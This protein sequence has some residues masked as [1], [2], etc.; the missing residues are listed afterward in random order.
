MPAPQQAAGS[1]NNDNALDFLWLVVIIVVGMALVWYFGKTP[2]TRAVFFVRQYELIAIQA[3]LSIWNKVLI[4]TQVPIPSANT[5]TLLQWQH[6][7]KNTPTSSVNFQALSALSTEVGR[8]LAYPIAGILGVLAIFIYRSNL[9]T[10]FKTIFNMQ[11][12]K[13]T[14]YHDWPQITPVL[15]TDLVKQDLKTGPWA[16]AMTPI[17]FCKQYQL[18]QITSEHG[19]NKATLLTGAA[20]R[21]FTLQLGS[22]WE[23]ADKL[24]LYMQALVAIFIARG[25]RD[26]ISADP[27]LQRISASANEGTLDF[28]GAV[29]LWRKHINSKNVQRVL[30]KH[31]YI[32][33]V[34]ASLIELAREDGVLATAEFLWLKPLDRKLWYML[35]SVGRQTAVPEIAGAFSHWLAEKKVG[36]PLKVPMVQEAVKSLQAALEEIVYTD[37]E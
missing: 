29:T 22:V 16:M 28:S 9:T 36:Q 23:G 12:L 27:I 5:Q 11:R 21:I 34:M 20:H 7:V 2:I 25:N 24:P 33:T 37:E 19:E 30:Q 26:R 32:Y 17:D 10:H 18:L 35:N 15:Q 14:E 8:Y 4:F 3:V 1:S 6:F 13:Q 31:A